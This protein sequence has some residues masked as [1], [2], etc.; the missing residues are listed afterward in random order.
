M[1][2]AVAPH[3]K[4]RSK[5]G[6]EVPRAAEGLDSDLVDS[7]IVAIED[8]IGSGE[9]LGG[10]WLR[11]EA[12]A[13]ELGVSRMPIRE[14]LRR[15]QTM[16]TIEVVAN[17]GARVKLPSIRGITET[18]E[19]RSLLEGH[20][21]ALACYHITSAQLDQMRDSDS[22]FRKIISD[23]K[24]KPRGQNLDARLEWV[25]AYKQFHAVMITATGNKRLAETIEGLHRKIPRNLTS[26]ALGTDVRLLERDADEHTQILDAIDNGDAENAQRLTVAHINRTCESIVHK[27]DEFLSTEGQ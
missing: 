19:I 22:K 4:R 13:Q 23:L 25:G 1:A 14:A 20:A 17:R 2:R 27:L 9:V 15:M 3:S 16:G 21:A 12:L 5:P 11:Q 7:L 18:F 26:M 24:D 10:A 6:G 8:R